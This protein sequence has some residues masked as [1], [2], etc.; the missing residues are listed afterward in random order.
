MRYTVS[1]SKKVYAG[2]RL[3]GEVF[4]SKELDDSV[5]PVEAGFQ[6]V[7]GYT[8]NGMRK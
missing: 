2:D 8:E 4:Y 5:T 6:A 7:K 3:L 1:V